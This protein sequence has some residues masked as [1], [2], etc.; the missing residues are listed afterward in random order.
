MSREGIIERER[1]WARPAAIAAF[2]AGALLLA[3]VIIGEAA[4][5]YSGASETLGLGSIH[6]HSGSIVLE[7]VVRAAA[8]VL[9]VGPVLYLFRAAQSR[10]ARVQAL[11]V[12]FVFI[13]PILLAAAG[14]V[15]A[16][17]AT[18]AASDF[19][20]LPPEQT[21]SFSQFSSQVAHDPNGI[22]KVTIYTQP[23]SL[24]VQ[25]TD[26]TFYKVKHY[27]DKAESG[28][29]SEL[30]KAGINHDSDPD[31]IAGDARA[32]HVTDDSGVL[33]A[34]QG[35]VVPGLLG[36]VVG[37][38]YVSLQ[39]LRA[40]LLTR[41]VGSF[42]IALGVA[43]IF[44]PPLV[45]LPAVLWA[46]FLAYL[47]LLYLGRAPGGRPPAWDAGEAIPWP[48]PGDE[49]SSAPRPS[50]DAIE[51]EATEGPASGEPAEGSPGGQPRSGRRK[52]KRRR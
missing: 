10:N 31:G 11:M 35:L 8:F 9:L 26:G 7:S 45:M 25:R 50:R 51:G 36:L 34:A 38:A 47:G 46:G 27:P 43:A 37:M 44:I 33:K 42:G 52:R 22:D 3:A 15:Q 4:N 14:V 40:G 32:V 29:S 23:N 28:L 39:A 16:V 19:V 21:R 49:Q 30:D 6:D 18:K 17:G 5:L 24:E 20:K 13:G 2:L 1:R 12:G 48:K 41:F